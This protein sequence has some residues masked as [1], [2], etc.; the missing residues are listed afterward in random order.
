MKR[1]IA[2]L[3]LLPQPLDENFIERVAAD[4]ETEPVVRI[5]RNAVTAA[6]AEKVSLNR[7]RVTQLDTS[8]SHKIDTW[9]VANQKK[10]GRCWL[11]SGLNFLRAHLFSDLKLES[12]EFSQN[13]LHFWDKLEKANWFLASMIEMADRDLDD[14]TVHQMLMDPIGDGGQWD[15][16]VNLVAKYGVVPKYAMPETESSSNTASMNQTLETL[17]RRGALELRGAVAE[18]RADVQELRA[19]LISEVYRLLTIHLGVPPRNFVWQYRDKDNKFTRKGTLTPREFAAQVVDANLDDYVSLVNDPRPSS[20]FGHTFTVDHLGNVVGGRPILYLN[21]EADDLRKIAM[22][23]LTSGK[24]VWMGCDVGKQYDRD[25]GYWAAD[26]HDYE[27]L[28]GVNLSISKAERMQLGESAMTHAMLFTGV[29][30]VDGR[31]RRWRVENSWGDEKGD[32][33]FWTM[34]DS[35]F[36]QYLFELAV[37]VSMLPRSLRAALKE[38][39]IVLP[40]WDPM[41]SLA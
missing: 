6:D 36:D 5:A 2:P 9:G 29:D 31:P 21:A 35:W 33:G 18:N 34:D 1:T 15:M 14:R 30:V 8:M 28:Y 41:G 39:P 38:T 25:L 12:F 32:K 7:E 16:F 37:P 23:L 11:F 24:P 3:K 20:P 27:G 40:L 22:D 19:S 10:S 26:L 13:Y 17:L 4:V